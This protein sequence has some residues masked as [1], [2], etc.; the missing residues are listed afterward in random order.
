[1]T[2]KLTKRL[3]GF[4][5]SDLP[6]KTRSFWQLAG[7]GA[8]LVG[9]SIGSSELIMWPVIVA[10]FGAG[11]IWAA[12]VGVFT[13]LWVNIERW[14]PLTGPL[15]GISKVDSVVLVAA[16]SKPQFTP[17]MVMRSVGKLPLALSWFT[18]TATTGASQ[19]RVPIPLNPSATESLKKSTKDPRGSNRMTS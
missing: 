18:A 16:K 15:G 7:P 10:T 8:I 9:L 2:T 1:M 19:V 12:G 14:T 4:E 11:M 6:A 5:V 13:Q 3:A 17:F